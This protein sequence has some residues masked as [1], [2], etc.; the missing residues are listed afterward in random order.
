MLALSLVA[1]CAPPPHAPTPVAAWPVPDGWKH[2][3]IR[4]P[5]DFAPDLPHKGLEEIRFA[6]GFFDP[7]APGYW[8]YAFAWR[9]EAATALEPGA[10]AGELTTYFRGLVAAVDDKHE[11]ADRDAI[12][13]RA[14]PA[15]PRVTLTAHVIDPFATKQ[16]VELS[17]TVTP[18]AC[19]SG[20]LWVFVFTPASSGMRGAVDAV[21]AQAACDQPPVPNQHQ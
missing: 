7:N 8:S 3:V 15:G 1:A 4:F 2:E 9:L 21:A 12:V 18:L 5:L 17:G 6:P 16:P 11:I 14:E 19:A 13:V 10:I 20:A